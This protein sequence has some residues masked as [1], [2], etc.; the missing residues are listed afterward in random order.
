MEQKSDHLGKQIT[1]KPS[2]AH[3]VYLANLL[4][5]DLARRRRLRRPRLPRIFLQPA[6]PSDRYRCDSIVTTT[7]PLL[8]PKHRNA[9]SLTRTIGWVSIQLGQMLRYGNPRTLRG[10]SS[11]IAT[12]FG[13]SLIHSR[14]LLG[15][16]AT[17]AV[18]SWI[19]KSR[20]HKIITASAVGSTLSLT[21]TGILAA[22][23]RDSNDSC[24]VDP[25]LPLDCCEDK[26]DFPEEC[27]VG[28][29][30]LPAVCHPELQPPPTCHPGSDN[31]FCQA[32]DESEWD[33]P[34]RRKRAITPLLPAGEEPNPPAGR[35]QLRKG[36]LT[37]RLPTEPSDAHHSVR[38]RAIVTFTTI[39][40]S[41]VSAIQL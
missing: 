20:N 27:C 15:R 14:R 11:Q 4:N 22:H 30:P 40:A 9:R 7:D 28:P 18:R 21:G 10:P 5:R 24:R 35:Q 3:C 17:N 13:T 34:V 32:L 38:K 41:I 33:G 19:R 31:V 36:S 12:L 25:P 2:R 1:R 16:N 39:V 29:E 6:N 37:L 26:N 8:R 23:R